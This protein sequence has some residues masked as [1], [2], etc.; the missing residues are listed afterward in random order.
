MVCRSIDTVMDRRSKKSKE[1]SGFS[2]FS[3]QVRKNYQE[4]LQIKSQDERRGGDDFRRGEIDEFLADIPVALADIGKD[5][6]EYFDAIKNGDNP[7]VSTLEERLLDLFHSD[8][9]LN[10]RSDA[11]MQSLAPPLRKEELRR[12]YRINYLLRKWRIPI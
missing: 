4:F 2:V 7:D 12:R 11:F 1:T 3:R 10:S 6:R 9:E 5:I 8:S